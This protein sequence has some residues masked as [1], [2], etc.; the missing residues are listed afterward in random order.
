MPRKVTSPRGALSAVGTVRNFVTV[1]REMS[2]EA[3]REQA[4]Q[5]PRI[6]IIA[7]DQMRAQTIGNVVT[8]VEN[9]PAIATWLLEG[10]SRPLDLYDVV[11]IY[12]PSSNE[13]FVKARERAGMDGLKIFDLASIEGVPAEWAEMLRERIVSTLPDLAPALGRWFPAFRPA[14]TKAVI[15]ETARVNAQFALVSNIPAALPIIGSLAA[16]GADFFVLTK[17]Q[18]MMVYKLAAI[19]GR[20]LNDHWSVMR[21]ITPVVGAGFV[22]RTAAR[23]AAAFIPLL[24]GTVPKVAIAFT[25]TLA[26]GYGADFYYRFGKKASRD[27]LRGYYEQAAESLKSLGDQIPGRTKS[28]E[29]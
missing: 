27:Q 21:E 16:V 23:E 6:L 19:H 20:D 25:G 10:A 9:S 7:S 4:E 12:N 13:Y 15:N 5:L 8:G 22:W 11:I 24:A 29:P 14:A 26:A 18:V 3:E 28:T 2:F 1:I 17:N